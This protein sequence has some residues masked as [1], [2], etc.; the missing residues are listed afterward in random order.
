MC[1]V[2]HRKSTQKLERIGYA[3]VDLFA[4]SRSYY[5]F[6]Q[7]NKSKIMQKQALIGSFL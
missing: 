6:Y 5:L 4:I 1:I 7:F 2:G 3:S